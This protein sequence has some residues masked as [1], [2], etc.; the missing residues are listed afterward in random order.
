MPKKITMTLSQSSIQNAIKELR[1]YQND[2]DRKCEEFCRRL[3]ELGKL[4]AQ[5]SV[6]ESPL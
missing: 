2:L 4:T 3:A 5:A 6:D 1:Q